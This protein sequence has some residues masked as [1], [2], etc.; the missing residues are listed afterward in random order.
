MSYPLFL[1]KRDGGY[2]YD[3]TDM[4]AIKHRLEESGLDWVVYVTD[5]R[6]VKRAGRRK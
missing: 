6:Q 5:K 1:R 2:G 3:S 4:A